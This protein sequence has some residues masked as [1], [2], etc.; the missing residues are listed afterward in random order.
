[1]R[2]YGPRWTATT[3]SPPWRFGRVHLARSFKCARDLDAKVA[4][5]RR[6]RLPRVVVE[7]DVVAVSSQPRLGANGP[8]RPALPPGPYNHAEFGSV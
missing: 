8:I 7:E 2:L 1:M 3:A 5:Y 6:A 4:Q